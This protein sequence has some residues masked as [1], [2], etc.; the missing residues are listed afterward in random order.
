MFSIT[1]S[2]GPR[3]KLRVT[4]RSSTPSR[5]QKAHNELDKVDRDDKE[6]AVGAEPDDRF[7]FGGCKRDA[8]DDEL[9]L[10]RFSVA[11]AFNDF[12][13]KDDVFEIEDREIVIVKF[14]RSVER[15]D[16]V[17]RTN[18]VAYSPDRELCPS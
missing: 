9:D 14:F 17:Q 5:L 7:G 3:P 8:T 15:N 16:I 10:S 2:D 12:A 1:R 4:L 18:T 11:L 13:G 6:R